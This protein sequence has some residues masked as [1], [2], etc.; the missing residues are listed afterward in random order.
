M[1][2]KSRDRKYT[3]LLAILIIR[4]AIAPFLKTGIG[5]IISSAILL[6]TI[7]LILRTFPLRK[8]L[9]FVY[10]AIAAIAFVLEVL[11]TLGLTSSANSGFTICLQLIYSA[12]LGIAAC[13]IMR[14]ILLASAVTLDIVSGGICVYLLIGFVWALFYGIVQTLDPNAFSEPLFANHVNSY[15]KTIYFSFTTLT[16]L[17]Y[18]DVVP[19]NDIALALTNLEAIIGQMYPAVFIAILVGGYLSQRPGR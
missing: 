8:P 1:Y 12:Y 4:F 14:E 9:F 13:W 16:T 10:S 18:G 6:C 7:I 5:S 2:L 19:K 3:Q 11:M 17:G 15:A